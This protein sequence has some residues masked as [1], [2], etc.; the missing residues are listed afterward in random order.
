MVRTG[1]CTSC[2]RVRKQSKSCCAGAGTI[3]I[4]RRQQRSD[5]GRAI[6]SKIGQ[7]IADDRRSRSNATDTTG[8]IT[9]DRYDRS[10]LRPIM[11]RASRS[12]LTVAGGPATHHHRARNGYP[13]GGRLRECHNVDQRQHTGHGFLRR[14]RHRFGLRWPVAI[15]AYHGGYRPITGF[16]D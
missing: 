5:R 16:T 11:K 2:K 10:G 4:D 6:G 3:Q 8:H 14:W 9:S 15:R 1:N 7:G 12:S 13:G